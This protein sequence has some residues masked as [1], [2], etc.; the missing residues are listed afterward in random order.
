MDKFK[1]KLYVYEN[2]STSLPPAVH[3]H[4]GYVYENQSTSLPPAVHYHTGYDEYG[5]SQTEFD[6]V[7]GIGKLVNLK[8]F[9]IGNQKV[10]FSE[11]GPFDQDFPIYTNT[12]KEDQK[13]TIDEKEILKLYTFQYDAAI[14]SS[15]RRNESSEFI[16]DTIKFIIDVVKKVQPLPPVLLYRGITPWMKLE[17][18]TKFS[19]LGF[20]SKSYDLNSAARFVENTCCMLILGYTKPSQHLF[21]EKFSKFPQEKELLTFPGEQFEVVEIGEVFEK[22]FEIKAYYCR[23]I[24]NIYNNDF[25]I[26]VNPKIDKDF[27]DF[28][29]PA[30]NQISD[31]TVLCMR[32]GEI[33]YKFGS[34]L[35]EPSP[36]KIKAIFHS[37]ATYRVYLIKVPLF[38]E[39]KGISYTTYIK[40]I[41]SN[42]ILRDFVNF[43]EELSELN[44]FEMKKQD[45]FLEIPK[46]QVVWSKT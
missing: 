19:D 42:K 43:V 41:L 40:G 27:D 22:Y 20:S 39:V 16:Y 17:V 8:K 18:G 38:E 30:I 15:L 21:M 37:P 3:Y 28:I 24:G 14:N 44:I 29:V 11:N 7:G 9:F 5:L 23:Y 31:T 1:E 36:F 46:A 34:V 4:T 25:D 33:V 12:D 2:Q 32:K 45:M 13:L 35:E 10:F 6:A 26:K